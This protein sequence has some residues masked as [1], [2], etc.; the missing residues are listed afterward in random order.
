MERLSRV[1]TTILLLKS[2]Y[3]YVPY[4]SLERIIE[5]NSDRYYMALRRA[6][7]TIETDDSGLKV[8]LMFF[9]NL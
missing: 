6:Q 3:L 4:C 7:T 9:L 8:W 5:M 2:G 1:L